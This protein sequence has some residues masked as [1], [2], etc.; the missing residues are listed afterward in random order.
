M[1]EI[2]TAIR[3]RLRAVSGV[4][5]LVEARIYPQVLPQDPVLPALTYNRVGGEPMHA[6]TNDVWEEPVIQ[7]DSY[8]ET[9]NAVKALA[10][11]VRLAL[12]RYSGTV[13]GVEIVDIIPR[14]SR[15]LYDDEVHAR[16]V[17]A[18]YEVQH[19]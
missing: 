7:I 10:T 16:R 3:T 14:N 11:Q 1:A 18:D 6:M 13:A 8:A 9:Y 12:Q 19:R 17:Q 4:T 5:D 2:E 15:D